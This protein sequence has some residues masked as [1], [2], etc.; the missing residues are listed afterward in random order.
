[1]GNAIEKGGQT[2]CGGISDGFN[3][4]PNAVH[5]MGHLK[6]AQTRALIA[7]LQTA[8][9]DYVFHNVDDEA[10]VDKLPQKIVSG[11]SSIQ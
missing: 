7:I 1:M 9:I 11:K 6:N 10:T 3:A 4:N 8:G 2:L 5:I